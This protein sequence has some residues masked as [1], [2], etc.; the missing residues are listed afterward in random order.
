MLSTFE[1]ISRPILRPI[2]QIRLSHSLKAEPR[3]QNRFHHKR[4]KSLAQSR[5]RSTSLETVAD[6][7]ENKISLGSDVGVMFS[8]GGFL[9]SYY[10]GPSLTSFL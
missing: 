2:S 9:V 3:R 5:I 10:L 6:V 4:Y 1:R 7:Y 8:P